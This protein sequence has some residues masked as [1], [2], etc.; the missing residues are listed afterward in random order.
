MEKSHKFILFVAALSAAV[1]FI[2]LFPGAEPVGPVAE[3]ASA[4]NS[5][6]ADRPAGSTPEEA[7]PENLNNLSGTAPKEA[8]LSAAREQNVSE[9]AL[10]GTPQPIKAVNG[11]AAIAALGGRLPKVA[12]SYGSSPEEFRAMFLADPTL[13]LNPDGELFYACRS[14]CAHCLQAEAAESEVVAESIGPTDPA[15][16]DTTEAFRLHS[17]P[18]ADRVIYLDF[19]GHVDNTPRGW[20]DGAAS[21][22]FDLD[23]DETSFNVTERNRIIKIWQRVAE[24]FSMYA[25]DVTTE[26]PGVE[27]LRR[28]SRTDNAYGVRVVIGGSWGDWYGNPAGGVAFVGS[29]DS[30]QD[31]PCWVFP[32]GAGNS[33]KNLAETASHEVGHTLG[34]FHD[35]LIGGPYYYSGQGNWGTIMGQSNRKPISQWSKGEYANAHNTQDDLAV[36]L[37]QGAVYR[38]DDHGNSIATATEIAADVDTALG[39]GVIERNTDLDFFQVDAVGGLL[40]INVLPASLG[41]NLRIEVKLYDAAGLLLETATSPDTSEGTQPVALSRTVTPGDYFISVEGIGNGDPLTTGYTDYSS[42]GRYNLSVNG[43]FSGGFTWEQSSGGSYL[44][45]NTANW[46][47]GDLPGGPESVVRI[48]NDISGNQTIELTNPITLGRF[49]LGDPNNTHTFTLVSSAD[50]I[51]FDNGGLAAELNKTG[52]AND[53]ISTPIELVDDLVLTQSAPGNLF[54]SGA[55]SG[56]GSLT[57]EGAGT[58]A[59]DSSNNYAGNTLLN[60]GLL[61][62]DVADGLPGGID[63]PAGSGE[64]LLIFNGG[65]L[66]LASG[67]FTRELGSDPGQL[68]WVNGSGGFAAFGANREVRLNNGTGALSWNSAIIGGGNSLLLS[69]S[70]ATHTL[71]F[72][73]GISF[74]GAQRIVRVEDGQDSV[75]AI[76]SG[77]LLGGGSSGL[78]KTGTGV[79]S[80]SNANTYAGV[81]TVSGGVLRLE[82][83]GALPSGNLELTE[84]GI[85]GLGAGDLTSRTLGNG[86]NQI[87]WVGEGGFA[88]FGAD[89]VV[90]FSD[91]SINWSAAHFIGGT[92]AL[93]LSH[94]TA[95]ASLD[96]QQKIS[97]AGSMRIIHVNDG[98]AGIDAKMSGVVAGGSSGTSNVFDKTGDGTLAFTA[99]NSYWGETIVRLGTLMIGDGGTSGG[100]SYNSQSIFV[101]AGATLAVNRSDTVTQGTDP[102]IAPI[103]GP[104]SF[105]QVGAGKTVFALGNTYTG[106][107]E[108]IAGTLTLGASDTLPDV[109]DVVIGDA[110][111]DAS[112]YTDSTG[113]LSVTGGAT[114][115]LGADAVLSFADSSAMGWA[116]GT[117]E[118]TGPFVSG[119]SLRF[120]TS[121]SGLTEAQLGLISAAG[122][123]NFGL[124]PDGYLTAS[125]ALSGY[126]AWKDANAPSTGDDPSADEDGDGVANGLEYALGGLVGTDDTSKLPQVSTAGGN[127]IFTFERSHD[128][129]DGS[130]SLEILVSP[131]MADWSTSYSVPD[132]P[133]ANNPGVTV[134]KDSRVGFDTVT[135]ALPRGLDVRKFAILKVAP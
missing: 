109:S 101:D 19:D 106:P 46:A 56:A 111:L 68:D 121:S 79:L 28:T 44:W 26:D 110:V 1:C 123:T 94:E 98:F 92:R 66:G 51:V 4:Q 61:R 48:N 55:I 77:V 100:V 126:T 35:G 125:S 47:S 76:L 45:N 49:F 83:P 22:P 18:G 58:V 57:K 20:K 75:D 15:P 124:D 118:I 6:A 71:D 112:A 2:L 30:G 84:A 95:E 128:S 8:S 81:T 67:D 133:T 72:K 86:E 11:E 7:A 127:F 116:S 13:W 21:P 27:A 80:L 78:L 25:I 12:A 9:P 88:A 42:L 132:G 37:T 97:L 89:R 134:L 122:L 33:E 14:S 108:L 16:F 60:D 69:H 3:N 91:D 63:H 52:G 102:L 23:G 115:R 114:I 103:T 96:W 50:S 113:M 17:R 40:D 62:L 5:Y 64:S 87:Q 24:D 130:T 117:L 29:F 131:D 53:L 135:L 34:L 38:S 82:N 73:N 70:S 129:I 85:L 120:G 93:I 74:A 99:Q 54:I 59:F 10:S 65:Q 43:V 104:G 32:G 31:Y 41:S 90:K 36:M 119:V 39:D 105:A 107:T